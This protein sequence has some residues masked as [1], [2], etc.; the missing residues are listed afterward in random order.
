MKNSFVRTMTAFLVLLSI[1]FSGCGKRNISS[2]AEAYYTYED[3]FRQAGYKKRTATMYMAGEETYESAE[4]LKEAVGVPDTLGIV[5]WDGSEQFTSYNQSADG[6]KVG[7]VTYS[8]RYA[9]SKERIAKIGNGYYTEYT[10]NKKGKMEKIIRYAG[11]KKTADAQVLMTIEFKYDAD[12]NNTV[13]S[14]KDDTDGTHVAYDYKLSYDEKG[15]LSRIT[16]ISEAGTEESYT[17]F[18]YNEKG[19]FASASRYGKDDRLLVYTEYTY[20]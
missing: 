15:K 5:E 12:D 4:V 1:F 19:V 8:C 17:D 10:Y 20:E 13:V 6:T 16:Y 18:T 7:A 2:T 14:V 11:D 3:L 9:N